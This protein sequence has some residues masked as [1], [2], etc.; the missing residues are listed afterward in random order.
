MIEKLRDNL[1]KGGKCG[2]LF[3]DLSKS[4]C[5]PPHDLLAKLNAYGFA[6]KCI[7]LVSSVPSN[8]EHRSKINS[9]FSNCEHLLVGVPQGSVVGLWVFNIVILMHL[10]PIFVL[11]RI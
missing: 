3:V 10:W 2:T 1:D 4:F 5:C 11:G 8:R 9:S 7:K 6:Y